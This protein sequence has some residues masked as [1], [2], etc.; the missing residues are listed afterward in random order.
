MERT[1]DR[2]CEPPPVWIAGLGEGPEWLLLKSI[3]C[4]GE[5][6]TNGNSY[7]FDIP[8]FVLSLSKGKRSAWATAC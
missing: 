4:F 8:P 3:S 1:A 7:D 6:S 2:L 5:L